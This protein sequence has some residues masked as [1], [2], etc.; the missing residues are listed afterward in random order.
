MSIK[1]IPL[2]K[3]PDYAPI[4]AY[5]SYNEW[6]RNREIKFDL[7]MKSH[8]SYSKDN[9]LPYSFVAFY[10]DYPVGMVSFKEN[11]L[12]SRKDINPWLSSLYVVPDY[13]K[14]GIAQK[15]INSVLEKAEMMNYNGIYLF[16]RDSN[17]EDLDKF[18]R[19]RGWE[20]YDNAI[21]N[22]GHNTK[23]FLFNLNQ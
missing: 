21:D 8:I 18:Y 5:W 15:L 14:M 9:L 2:H 3:C 20:F 19:N 11:D 23:I 6:Y 13:R 1:I 12:W 16:F 22:D 10:R 4:L 7:V 17:D